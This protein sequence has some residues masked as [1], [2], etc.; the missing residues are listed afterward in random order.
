MNRNYFEDELDFQKLR[1]LPYRND[2]HTVLIGLQAPRFGTLF[3]SVYNFH[4]RR[5]WIHREGSGAIRA[6]LSDN[7]VRLSL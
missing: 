5:C 2:V 7:R 1:S 3:I 4:V 6:L